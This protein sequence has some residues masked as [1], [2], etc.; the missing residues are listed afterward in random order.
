MF[1]TSN[2]EK[3]ELNEESNGSILII[4]LNDPRTLNSMNQKMVEELH[5]IFNILHT[6]K[7]SKYKVVLIRGNGKGF[8]SG[9][10][11]KDFSGSNTIYDSQN[12][13]G[14]FD[15]QVRDTTL[16]TK[17]KKCPQIVIV[18]LHGVA[19]GI[20]MGFIFSADIV[21]ACENAKLSAPFLLLGLTGNEMGATFGL[22]KT[23]GQSLT[24]ELLLTGRF[25]TAN[26]CHQ[27]SNLFAHLYKT[28]EELKTNSLKMA[29]DMIKSSTPLTLKLTKE[30]IYFA[31][32][33]NLDMETMMALENRNQ[34]ITRGD[35]DS[36]D[37][38][39]EYVKRL[40]K[41]NKSSKL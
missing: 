30:V 17:I 32:H 12:V 35:K 26:E 38:I 2:Y 39:M 19:V 31:N 16:F 27:K 21:L 25:I 3:I 23:F 28:Q 15:L 18:E 40:S 7:G 37:K 33:K 8:C 29:N 11:L 22:I 24:S 4:S 20:A 5:R 36:L 14:M 10:N 6:N 9:A 34:S 41:K 1:I 13:H